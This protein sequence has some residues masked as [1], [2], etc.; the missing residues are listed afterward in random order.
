MLQNTPCRQVQVGSIVQGFFASVV[1]L[2]NKEATN[3]TEPQQIQPNQ[4]GKK[5]LRTEKRTNKLSPCTTAGQEVKPRPYWRK[6]SALPTAQ[7]CC[8]Y[9]TVCC[10]RLTISVFFL[11]ALLPIQ[12]S[13]HFYCNFFFFY[14]SWPKESK[15]AN[16][17]LILLY[18]IC[19]RLATG[20]PREF[21]TACV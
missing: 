1:A 16:V 13:L 9:A 5:S 17:R 20:K 15:F 6:A 3:Q 21:E 10:S 2:L 8:W 18:L 11:P 14:F 12:F 7:P 4:K 19:T